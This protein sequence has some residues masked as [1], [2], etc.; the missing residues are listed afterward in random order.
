MPNRN[1]KAG[2]LCALISA[3]GAMLATGHAHAENVVLDI[4]EQYIYIDMGH[5]QGVAVAALPLPFGQVGGT[6]AEVVLVGP[7]Q[8][9]EVNHGGPHLQAVAQHDAVRQGAHPALGARVRARGLR[10]WKPCDGGTRR[11]SG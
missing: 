8:P 5:D 10:S 7:D 3:A 4:Q 11:H 6:G 9:I 2:L 1:S